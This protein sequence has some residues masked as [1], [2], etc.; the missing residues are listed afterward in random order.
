MDRAADL[1]TTATSLARLVASRD[2]EN[3]R[4]SLTVLANSCNACHQSFKVKKRVVP[5][6]EA[7]E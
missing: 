3:S 1:R 7:E 6:A 4:K 2:Y 5:F